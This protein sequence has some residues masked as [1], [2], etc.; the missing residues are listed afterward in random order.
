MP[1][2]GEVWCRRMPSCLLL[3]MCIKLQHDDLLLCDD[4]WL[5]KMQL[6]KKVL[7][8][9]AGKL[10]DIDALATTYIYLQV[11]GNMYAHGLVA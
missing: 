6:A 1:G 7:V 10:P 2:A 4:S 11:R 9:D 3:P 8:D 5:G